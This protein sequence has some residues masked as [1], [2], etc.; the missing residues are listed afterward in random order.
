[1]LEC[2]IGYIVL[3]V[4][5]NFFRRKIFV[6]KKLDKLTIFIFTFSTAI[7][8]FITYLI[9]CFSLGSIIYFIAIISYVVSCKDIYNAVKMYKSKNAL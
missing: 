4:V 8:A 1:M 5:S 7:I 3:I 2:L 9:A 6:Y